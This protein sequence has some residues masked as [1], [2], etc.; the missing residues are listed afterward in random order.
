MI[1]VRHILVENGFSGDEINE[2]CVL[3]I[4][5]KDNFNIEHIIGMLNVSIHFKEAHMI[6]VNYNDDCHH[7]VE[8]KI[9]PVCL[10]KEFSKQFFDCV[11]EE[12]IS[13]AIERLIRVARRKNRGFS[14]SGK[15]HISTVIR[16]AVKIAKQ[17]DLHTIEDF[18]IFLEGLDEE[19]LHIQ[20]EFFSELEC[21]SAS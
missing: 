5:T 16:K 7:Y 6:C 19:I 10:I 4:I 3:N 18:V 15:T 13:D 1:A 17:N 14:F 20:E 21:C 12:E 11:E 2:Q 8:H 9:I